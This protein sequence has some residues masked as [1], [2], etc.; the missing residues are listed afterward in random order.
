L[1]LVGFFVF[2]LLKITAVAASDLVLS[3]IFVGAKELI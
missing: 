2:W 3:P 1:Q